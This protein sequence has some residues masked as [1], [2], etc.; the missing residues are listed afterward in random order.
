MVL[1]NYSM[2]LRTALHGTEV[3]RLYPEVIMDLPANFRGVH[4]LDATK[5][6][7]CGACARIC[8]NKCIELVPFKYGNPTKNK[9]ML[10][11]QIDYGRCMFCG[12]CVDECPVSCLKMGMNFEISG[13]ERDKIIYGPEMIAVVKHTEEEVAKLAEEA[14]IAAEKKK[15]A[16][17]AKAAKEK[18]EKAK[19]AGKKDEEGES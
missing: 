3:T 18:K 9:K 15:A 4:E 11:P 6:I 1:K 10:F 19:E 12:L 5:C 7:G 16:K 13:W 14:R 8:T 2:T 17:K